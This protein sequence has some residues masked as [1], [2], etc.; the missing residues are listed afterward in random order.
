MWE[1]ELL[2][3]WN[4]MLC[5]YEF[6]PSF[7]LDSFF[8]SFGKNYSEIVRPPRRGHNMHPHLQTEKP[9]T[10]R[11]FICTALIL[12]RNPFRRSAAVYSAARI[13]PRKWR[14]WYVQRSPRIYF[15]S[16]I[17]RMLLL[18][19]LWLSVLLRIWQNICERRSLSLPISEFFSDPAA[20]K[21][22]LTVEVDNISHTYI[23]AGGLEGRKVGARC[24][25][26][27]SCIYHA[28]DASP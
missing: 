17:G 18:S 26:W 4:I 8:A 16:Y 23:R 2:V 14:V 6:P 10:Q 27:I 13:H 25:V 5:C 9:L 1:C 7:N 20:G 28:Y 3:R 21:R 11:S 22:D 12:E 15:L 24:R 19:S